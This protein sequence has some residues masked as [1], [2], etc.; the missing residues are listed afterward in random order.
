M[1]KKEENAKA[2][3]IINFEDHT[4]DYKFL[5]SYCGLKFQSNNS[6]QQHLKLTHLSPLYKNLDVQFLFQAAASKLEYPSWI[7]L[8]SF[9]ETEIKYSIE[10]GWHSK[11]I[12]LAKISNL[13]QENWSEHLTEWRNNKKV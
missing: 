5:C 1:S 10:N 8:P 11:Q 7:K 13:F 3:V 6:F 9:I 4:L 2:I 12:F